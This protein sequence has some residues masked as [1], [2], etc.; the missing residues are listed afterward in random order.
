MKKLNKIKEGIEL[1]AM[2]LQS[3]MASRA[4]LRYVHWLAKED[5]I[6][7][8]EAWNQC[9]GNSDPVNPDHTLGYKIADPVLQ[10]ALFG[11]LSKAK[12]IQAAKN[13]AATLT[14]E[15]RERFYKEVFNEETGQKFKNALKKQKKH[16]N[17]TKMDLDEES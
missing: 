6:S 17:R 2:N 12:R 15:E 11:Q 5:G 16:K 8:D 4:Q 9:L 13:F 14:D 1:K 7:I 10:L 3:D